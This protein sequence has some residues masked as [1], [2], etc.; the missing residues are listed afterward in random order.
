MTLVTTS[1]VFIMR[2]CMCSFP[3]DQRRPTQVW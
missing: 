1:G 2:P 3:D